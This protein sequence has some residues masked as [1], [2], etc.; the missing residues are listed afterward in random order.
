MLDININENMM[1]GKGLAEAVL[2][3]RGI[4]NFL[5]LLHQIGTA[6]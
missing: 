1:T 5:S 4:S 6:Q 2:I 3:S